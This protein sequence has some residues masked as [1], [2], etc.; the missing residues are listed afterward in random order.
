MSLAPSSMNRSRRTF[1]KALGLAGLATSGCKRPSATAGAAAQAPS[2]ATER[3]APSS[4]VREASDRL[5][6]VVRSPEVMR[7]DGAIDARRTK[8]MLAAAIEAILP[9]A[10]EAER[11]GHCFEPDDRVALKANCLGGPS[12]STRPEVCAAVVDSLPAAGVS[13]DNI[14]IYD[15]DTGEL[16]AAGFD[17]GGEAPRCLGSDVASYSPQ[18]LTSGKVGTCL[19][20]IVTDFAT[21]IVNM[22]LLKDHDL[23]GMSGALKNHF[24]SVHNPNKLHGMADERCSPY[25]A[26]LNLIPELRQT[27]RLVVMDALRACYDGGPSYNPEGMVD[28]GALIV[29]LNALAVDWVALQTLDALRAEHGLPELM[30]LERAPKYLNV[31]VDAEHQLGPAASEVK[32]TKIEL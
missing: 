24:G 19:S 21:A 22:P 16:A 10:T 1:L 9:G 14:L 32:V 11:W 12:F 6:A 23:A 28:Y 8:R 2:A 5:V 29:G 13:G 30:S 15:R 31:A 25:V 17:T 20:R 4:P 18:V 7:P 26:D 27:G 3:T